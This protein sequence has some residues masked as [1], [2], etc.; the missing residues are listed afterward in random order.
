MQTLPSDFVIEKALN[1]Y[2]IDSQPN[3]PSNSDMICALQELGPQHWSEKDWNYFLEQRDEA[4]Q[5]ENAQ[6]RLES[7][8]KQ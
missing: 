4:L 3:L 5:Q 6:R 8:E 7:V 1:Y 2:S